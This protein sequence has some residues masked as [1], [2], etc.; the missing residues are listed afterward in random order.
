M[1]DPQQARYEIIGI[2]Y[3]SLTRLKSQEFQSYWVYGEEDGP[4]HSAHY[5]WVIRGEGRTILVDTGFSSETAAKRGRSPEIDPLEALARIGIGIAPVDVDHV[6]LSHMHFD[7]I[8]NLAK[9][10]RASATVARAEL[11]FWTGDIARKRLF[12]WLVV[13]EEIE[14]IVRFRDEGRLTL[15][16]DELEILPGIRVT[17][18]G[19]HTDGSIIT[20]VATAAGRTILAADA[21]HTHEELEKDWSYFIFSN[22]PEMYR[23]Y[24]LLRQLAETPGTTVVP[25]HDPEVSRRFPCLSDA[26]PSHCTSDERGQDTP[27]DNDQSP[28]RRQRRL[29]AGAAYVPSGGV[30]KAFW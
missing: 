19:G 5:F 24:D 17:R 13:P 16:D 12:S 29:R 26:T 21:L 10:P 3:A 20:E 14:T 1:A 7:H 30:S 6:V 15:V 22:L 27:V 11:D 18:V 2:R 8:G 9:F 4:N 25:G 28:R 23:A